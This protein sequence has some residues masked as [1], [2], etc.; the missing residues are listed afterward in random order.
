MDNNQQFRQ[1]Y[2]CSFIK[3]KDDVL[4]DIARQY[5]KECE[6][7]DRLICRGGF[8]KDG[9]AMPSCQEERGLITK[10]ATE[11]RRRLFN[12]VQEMGFTNQ[13]FS[14]AIRDADAYRE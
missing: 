4:R 2:L 14:K 8:G 9:S 11:T 5:H 10:H 3:E 13:Q 12:M 6:E 1:E 7:Y